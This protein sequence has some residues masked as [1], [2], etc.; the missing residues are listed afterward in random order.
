MTAA[1]R[2]P[3]SMV[4]SGQTN[5]V[6][7]QLAAQT[8]DQSGARAVEITAL[9]DGAVQDVC[10][11]ANPH[12]GTISAF[13]KGVLALS[14]VS[15]GTVVALFGSA[16]AEVRAEKATEELSQK[17]TPTKNHSKERARDAA[18]GGLL[19]LGTAGLLYGIQRLG[20]ERGEREYSVGIDPRASYKVSTEGLP[21]VRFPLVRSTGNA[22]E[23]VV[24]DAMKGTVTRDGKQMDL[25][26]YAKSERSARDGQLADSSVL[27]IPDGVRFSIEHGGATFLVQSVA[28]PR[29]YPVPLR[30]DWATQSY[31]GAVMAG[32]AAFVGMMFA[33]PPDARSLS[34]D[35]FDMV[36][37]VK[38][39]AKPEAEEDP[40]WLKPQKQEKQTTEKAASPSKDNHAKLRT[41]TPV[42]QTYVVKNPGPRSREEKQETARNAAANAGIFVAMRGSMAMT[43]FSRESVFG[44]DA[45]EAMDN[46][47]GAEG[48]DGYSS[49]GNIVGIGPIGGGGGDGTIGTGLPF[50]PGGPGGRR[51]PAGPGLKRYIAHAPVTEVGKVEVSAGTMDREVIRR[52]IRSHMKEV[53]YC[54]EK[55]LMAH[56]ELEGRVQV[57]FLIGPMGKVATSLIESSSLRNAGTEQCVA[58]AVRRWEFPKPPSGPV[59]VTYPF[60]FKPAG[61]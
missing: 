10:H 14:A 18:A 31:T 51:G 36:R 35:G 33:L 26:E 23:L 27:A 41:T 50:G 28:K 34:L 47:V 11:L 4:M 38:L 40:A 21:S 61:E 55:E 17:K 44:S 9:F 6:A 16:Y 2:L 46:V 52:V 54:Y 58:E 43:V 37:L 32:A 48:V 56:K 8:D 53:K 59:T 5:P 60:V 25:H 45:K 39:N 1:N 7:N 3:N 30:I 12:A 42:P 49:G 13:T 20:S 24:A 15:L 19:F 29:H 22:F 57:K